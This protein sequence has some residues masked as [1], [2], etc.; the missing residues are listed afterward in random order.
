MTIDI[1]KII[2]GNPISKNLMK[3]W[4]SN[5]KPNSLRGKMFNRYTGPGNDLKQQLDFNPY[6]GEIYKIH[7]QPSSNNDRCSML[8]DV[9][10]TV[11]E[12][13]GKDSKDIKNIKL[14]A[15]KEW[16][17][18]FKVRTPYDLAAYSAIKSKKLLGL[19]NNFTM[20]DLSNELN[21]GII[22]KFER[23]KVIVNHIDEIHSCDLVDMQKYFRV[24]RGYKYIFTN[25]D[26]FSKYAFAFPIKSKT[27]KD[28][29]P[30]FEK[31]FKQRKR[32]YIWTDQE[33]A[34]FSKEMLKFFENNN[35]K[36][37]HTYSNL[38][39][40]IIERFNR[41]LRELMMKKFVKSNNTVWYNILPELIKTYNNRYHRTIKMKPI[42]VN[43]TNEKHI[44]NTVYNYDITNKKPKF[45]I[46]DLVRISLKR[47]QLFDKPTGNIKWSE[48]LFKIYKIN[49]SNVIT[50]QLKDM[51]DE[52]IKGIFNE[53]Q[54]QL[55]KNT[56]GE[57]IIEKILKTKGNQMY[58]KWRG[59][60]NN[61]NSWVNKYDIKKYL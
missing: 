14:K 15:D 50:Y 31:I 33:S 46:N 59:Y 25:I 54:L 60:S 35:V 45:K 48:E 23:K 24:N 30:C 4:G 27:I 26:I 47:R 53:K 40:V 5:T 1:H 7:D 19:G 39:A 34:F 6:T 8:H 29:K 37:Y 49:K 57:Y 43:K 11:A 55:T 17:D 21:K 44:K 38:K 58:V 56:T 10:Y 22:N 12:N 61:F 36:I 18:C 51:N 20:E 16:L 32:K 42:D 9:K 41:S 52:I 2:T 3:P 13:I 28:I